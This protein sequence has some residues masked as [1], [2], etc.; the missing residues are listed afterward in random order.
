MR[1]YLKLELPQKTEKG[2]PTTNLGPAGAEVIK[3]NQSP[4]QQRPR[5]QDQEETTFSSWEVRESDWKKKRRQV[6]SLWGYLQ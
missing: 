6:K 3:E 1:H 4:V 2:I 5:D